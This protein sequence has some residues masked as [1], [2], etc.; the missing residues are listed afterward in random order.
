MT[1]K[2]HRTPKNNCPVCGASLDAATD[3]KPESQGPSI[4]DISICIH[5]TT[6]LKFDENM[7]TK[8]VT[9]EE[10]EAFPDSVKDNLSKG[11]TIIRDYWESQKRMAD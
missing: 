9:Q 11:V 8:L 10:F 5:C 1:F 6:I 4:G 2:S 3:F 7:H